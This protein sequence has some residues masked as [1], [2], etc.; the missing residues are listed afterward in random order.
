MRIAVSSSPSAT[1]PMAH[2]PSGREGS[3]WRMGKTSRNLE[4]GMGRPIVSEWRRHDKV[5]PHPCGRHGVSLLLVEPERLTENRL[6]IVG[7]P[8]LSQHD[9]EV[10]QGIG[11]LI[12]EVGPPR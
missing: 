10:H 12:Y 6:G 8:E 7:A 2:T 1:A 5:R 9:A 11:P 4:A 3:P